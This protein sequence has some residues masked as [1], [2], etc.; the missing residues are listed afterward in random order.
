MTAPVTSANQADSLLSTGPG[1]HGDDEAPAA[2]LP[3]RG[4]ALAVLGIAVVFVIGLFAAGLTDTGSG[5]VAPVASITLPGGTT[6][7]LVPAAPELAP[8]T[9]T[10]QPPA[11]ILSAL[12]VP[13]G[14]QAHGAPINTDQGLSQYDRTMPFVV[15]MSADQVVA[16][17]RT[18]LPRLGWS[19]IQV[20]PDSF[21][22]GST[23]ILAKRGS[24]DGY[25]WEA[26]VVVSPMTA[27]AT[28]PF[29]LR[30]FEVSTSA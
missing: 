9:S 25:Y 21:H 29:S 22:P 5:T 26:G 30:L 28:T 13:A 17:F 23:E 10:G 7:H 1:G 14:T 8:I 16:T 12:E 18:L 20:G 2:A 27:A 11:D 4:P 3:K 24:A 6:V 15:D 19:V